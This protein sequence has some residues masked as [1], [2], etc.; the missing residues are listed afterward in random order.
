MLGHRV[1]STHKC[2]CCQLNIYVICGVQ[3]PIG[4]LSANYSQIC[5]SCCEKQNIAQTEA[6]I[7]N[8]SNNPS[9]TAISCTE[10]SLSKKNNV[11][12]KAIC[13]GNNLRIGG[14]KISNRKDYS[15]LPSWCN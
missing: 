6:T 11:Q 10:D 14:K 2:P 15:S 4:D 9:T 8:G 3:N 1:L 13:K 7:S 12:L 5:F